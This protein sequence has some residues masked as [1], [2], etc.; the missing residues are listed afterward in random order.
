MIHKKR[1][2]KNVLFHDIFFILLVLAN[3]SLNDSIF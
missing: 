2:Y 1:K 3:S